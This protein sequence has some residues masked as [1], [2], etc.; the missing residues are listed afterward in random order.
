MAELII[1]Y[2]AIDSALLTSKKQL[3]QNQGNLN[4]KIAL[5]NKLL[6]IVRLDEKP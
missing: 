1:E 2:S 6:E 5:D 3:E 4:A